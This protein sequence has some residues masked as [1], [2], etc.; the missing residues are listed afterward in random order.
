MEKNTEQLTRQQLVDQGYEM[1]NFE[2]NHSGTNQ[3]G[4]TILS[5]NK[6]LTTDEAQGD[7]FVL[8][9]SVTKYDKD[10]V[11]PEVN[12]TSAAQGVETVYNKIDEDP[13][14]PST[15]I[16][17]DHQKQMEEATDIAIY[18]TELTNNQNQLG[19]DNTTYSVTS[20]VDDIIF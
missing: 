2:I 13:I 9:P 14:E 5:E 10:M 17:V 15:V 12:I 1:S 4:T 3:E 7:Y 19:F 20:E 8:D 16:K 11:I 18:H 6:L